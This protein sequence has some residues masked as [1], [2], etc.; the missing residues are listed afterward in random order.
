MVD[1]LQTIQKHYES[2]AKVRELFQEV[3]VKSLEEE[4]VEEEVQASGRKLYKVRK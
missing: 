3:L 2:T 1:K 4:N